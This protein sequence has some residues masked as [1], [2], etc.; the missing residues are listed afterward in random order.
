[1]ILNLVKAF[2]KKS[3]NIHFVI[4]DAKGPYLKEIPEN[5][6]IINLNSRKVIFSIPKLITYL[7]KEKPKILI[8]TLRRVNIAAIIARRLGSP[9]TKLIIR[10]PN[11]YSKESLLKSKPMDRFISAL[12][13]YFY[14]RADAIV[15]V[16]NS[17]AD[18]LVELLKIPK[19]KVEVIYNPVVDDEL[20][21]NKSLDCE[22]QWIKEK[23]FKVII[24]MGRITPQKDFATLIK[25]FAIVKSKINSK[26][27]ILGEPDR[28]NDEF[29]KLKKLVKDLN[30]DY[31]VS[32]PGFVE[33]PFCYLSRAD[34]FVL[35]SRWEGLPGALIQ[36]LACG[37]PVVSVDC[38]TGPSE[39]LENG[40]YGYLSKIG[41]FET[42][43]KNMIATLNNPLSRD[44]LETR[45]FEFNADVAAEKYLEVINKIK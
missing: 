29:D 44:V 37:C 1:M 45:G 35:S 43:A 41:D 17:M 23:E 16:S 32:F 3:N 20:I 39:I 21:H 9:S 38:P 26:L 15:A 7:K 6:K 31:D 40:R 5:I 8:T 24:G 42:L 14:P 19:T 4:A 12:T 13:K 22:H 33:N 11:T 2:I 25:A 18:E 36:A 28:N 34:L 10:E 30:L 27:L